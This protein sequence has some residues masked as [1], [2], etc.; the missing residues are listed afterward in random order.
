MRPPSGSITSRIKTTSSP[1]FGSAGETVTLTLSGWLGL[2]AGS[3]RNG[4]QR[5]SVLFRHTRVVVLV[6]DPGDVP[7]EAS[8]TVVVVVSC[9]AGADVDE[10]VRSAPV[11]PEA[12][13]SAVRPSPPSTRAT[14]ST[15]SADPKLPN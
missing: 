1:T 6:A 5:S 8:A 7:T 9:A 11:S 2:G 12:T 10:V 15:A 3:Q 14:V 13:R 4:P